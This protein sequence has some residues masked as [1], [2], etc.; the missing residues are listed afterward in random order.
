MTVQIT[1]ARAR[2]HRPGRLQYTLQSPAPAHVG[3]PDV[4]ANSGRLLGLLE[5]L[6]YG[7]PHF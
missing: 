6:T 2:R 7:G 3:K 1:P 5:K 4:A